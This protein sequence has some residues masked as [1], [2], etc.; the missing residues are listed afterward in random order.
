MSVL[1]K[2]QLEGRYPDYKPETPSFDIINA[3][4]TST[5]DLLICLRQKL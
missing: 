5:K 4:L 1:M 2:Y 3:Y